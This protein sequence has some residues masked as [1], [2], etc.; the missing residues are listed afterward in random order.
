MQGRASKTLCLQHEPEVVRHVVT[1]WSGNSYAGVAYSYLPVGVSGQLYD[2]LAEPVD[3][4]LFFAG[5]VSG[6]NVY[7]V[8]NFFVPLQNCEY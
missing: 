1:N 6:D 8:I 2:Q 4:K 5:E 3:N 7:H